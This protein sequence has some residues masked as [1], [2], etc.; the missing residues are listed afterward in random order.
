MKVE[1]LYFDGCPNV[2]PTVER[3]NRILAET[4]LNHPV[5]LTRVG[6]LQTAQSVGFLGS[7][8]IRINGV[9]IEPSARMRTDSGIM[10][11]TYDGSGVPSEAL[12]RNA[13]TEAQDRTG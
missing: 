9:D 8:T 13:F 5:T 6:D 1:I 7:P 12:I 11:R 2:T 3:L 10:C 4:G